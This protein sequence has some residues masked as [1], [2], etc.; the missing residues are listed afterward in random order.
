MA[1]KIHESCL[2]IIAADFFFLYIYIS[3]TKGVQKAHECRVNDTK[4]IPNNLLLIMHKSYKLAHMGAVV[5]YQQWK[6]VK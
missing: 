4:Q 1:L 5:V 2:S 6:N 3:F